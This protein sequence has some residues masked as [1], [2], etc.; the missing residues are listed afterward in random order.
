MSAAAFDAA[1]WALALALCVPGWGGRPGRGAVALVAAVLLLYVPVAGVTPLAVLR[2][3]F[4]TPA[5]TSLVVLAALFL[6]RATRRPLFAAGEALLVAALAA[7][8]GV[9]FY[10][11]V[12]GAGPVDP[13]AWGYDGPWLAL[14]VGTVALLSGFA[15]RWALGAGLVLALAAWRVRG[16]DSPNLWDYVIDPMLAV[17]GLTALLAAGFGRL[18]TRFAR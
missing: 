12:L 14:A 3:V 18:R 5:V 10:P 13:Y 7:V 9:A 2:G 4:A 8:T 16:L 6:A 1:T 11:F 17:A 15:G